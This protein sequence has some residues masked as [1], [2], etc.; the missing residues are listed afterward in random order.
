[1]HMVLRLT[2]VVAATVDIVVVYMWLVR[3]WALA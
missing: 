2:F 3:P 1:M